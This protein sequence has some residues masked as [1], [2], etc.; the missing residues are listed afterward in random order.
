[1]SK[2]MQRNVGCRKKLAARLASRLGAVAMICT[3]GATAGRADP[4]VSCGGFAMLGGAQIASIMT[5]RFMDATGNG[6]VSDAIRCFEYCLSKDTQVLS[7]SWG[8]VD[9]SQSLQARAAGTT[10][11]LAAWGNALRADACA[12]GRPRSTTWRRGGRCSWRLP[13]TTA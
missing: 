1:M 10:R 8:G 5:C 3:L 11:T 4:A 9:Y 6:W 2:Q 12:A 7:N 13:A